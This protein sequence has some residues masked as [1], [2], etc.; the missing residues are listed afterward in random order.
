[1]AEP[2]DPATAGALGAL[3]GLTEFLPVSSSGHVAVGAWLFGIRDMPLA[4]VVVLH[5]GTLVAT[6]LVVGGDAWRLATN[7]FRGLAHPRELARSETG[8]IVGGV[9]VASIPTAVLGLWL[10]ERVEAWSH[11]PGAVGGFFLLSAVAVLTTR[12]REGE[13]RV[14]GLGACL[15]IGLAQGLAVLP[16]VSRSGSTIATAMLLG[17]QPAEAFRFS[18]LMSLP[19]VAGALALQLSKP[20]ALARLGTGALIGG[21]VALLVG[22]AALVVLRRVV[23]RGRFWLFA[24]Y[25]MPLGGGLVV[26]ELGS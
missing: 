25:L 11:S 22:W 6:L 10:E 4:M 3:Q 19:A 17:M 7:T 12:R 24:L 13:L 20:D 5:A 23:V 15:L 14:P 16:G 2:M 18:F 9:I 1:M 8:R 26:W 21:V